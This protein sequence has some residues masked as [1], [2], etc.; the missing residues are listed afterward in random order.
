MAVTKKEPKIKKTIADKKKKSVATKSMVSFAIY[1][2]II[3][4]IIFG[5]PRFLSKTLNTP[6]PMAAITSGSMWPAL[7]EGDLVFIKGIS[8]E[9]IKVGDIIV[10]R[11]G[12]RATFTIHRVVSLG[13]KTIITK[14]DANFSEDAPVSYEDVI[15]RAVNLRGKPVHIPYLGSIT[16]FASNLKQGNN[17]AQ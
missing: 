12:E 3:F 1:V 5:L 6:Y 8:G 4:V 9:E 11:N 10:Y 16:V 15:G 14:G 7:E 2:A 13:E 17:N